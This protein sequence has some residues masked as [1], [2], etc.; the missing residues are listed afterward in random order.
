MAGFFYAFSAEQA[1]SS[2]VVL[3]RLVSLGDP[4]LSENTP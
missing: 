1:Q 3:R 4:A 2:N